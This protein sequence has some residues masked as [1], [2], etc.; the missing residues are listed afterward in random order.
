MFLEEELEKR[1]KNA[2]SP[3]EQEVNKKL[4]KLEAQWRGVQGER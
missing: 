1:L 2:P 3:Q 4:A